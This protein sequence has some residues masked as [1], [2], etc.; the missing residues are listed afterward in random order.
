M[1]RLPLPTGAAGT[2]SQDEQQ[3][4]R[5]GPS[6]FG[7]N[8]MRNRPGGLRPRAPG[9]E[10]RPRGPLRPSDQLSTSC[11]MRASKAERLFIKVTPSGNSSQ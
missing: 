1:N 9:G 7:R 3:P 4:K 10:P 5:H 6:V 2:Q 8:G 11:S